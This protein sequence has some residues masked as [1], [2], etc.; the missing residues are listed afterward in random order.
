MIRTSMIAMTFLL[1]G[2][3]SAHHAFSA[4]YDTD[5]VG[6]YG[7]GH[8]NLLD[9]PARGLPDPD[10]RRGSLEHRDCAGESPPAS[11]ARWVGQRGRPRAFAL[12][13]AENWRWRTALI[14]DAKPDHGIDPRKGYGTRTGGAKALHAR[15]F[16]YR[17]HCEGSSW[18]PGHRVPPLGR[19]EVYERSVF[20]EEKLRRNRERD[21]QVR[22]A[23]CGAGW[24][25]LAVWECSIRGPE[26]REF[27]QVIDKSRRR[28]TGTGT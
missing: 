23:L 3:A 12:G 13:V 4:F 22:E 9:Q 27:E 11:R 2:S 21:A 5:N 7:R 19:G 6:K 28:L 16:R 8:R 18:K 26:R 15:G 10:G 24:R 25:C 14:G 1:A 20:R 17:S